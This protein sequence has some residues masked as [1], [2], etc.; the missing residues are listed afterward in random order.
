MAEGY[1]RKELQEILRLIADRQTAE[2]KAEQELLGLQ[3]SNAK[4]LALLQIEN[5]NKQARYKEQQE[6]SVNEQLIKMG[7]K[8][9]EVVARK[10]LQE[11]LTVLKKEQEEA[12][13]LAGGDQAEI[14]RI[15]KTYAAKRK[16]EKQFQKD[17]DKAEEARSKAESKRLVQ[18]AQHALAST[19]MFDFQA[20]KEVLNDF[21][22]EF[23]KETGESANK[24]D[25][26]KLVLAAMTE[27]LANFTKQFES[28]IKDIAYAQ[29]AID[30]RLQ[31]SGLDKLMGSY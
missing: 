21:T 2:E 14:K 29:S 28:Q 18:N 19:K 6:Q 4:R 17:I 31:G 22:A 30:T 3:I 13:K 26:V 15:N 16:A 8:A 10:S 5:I 27:R 25:Q 11:R 1:N 23:K 20:M 7:Y 9:A 12:I 24:G